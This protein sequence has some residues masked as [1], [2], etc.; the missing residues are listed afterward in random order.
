VALFLTGTD[1]S[2]SAGGGIH[3]HSRDFQFKTDCWWPPTRVSCAN[4]G[5]SA[6]SA[7]RQA[8]ER[9]LRPVLM[10]TWVAMLG[11]L[12]AAVSA[13]HRLGNPETAGHRGHRR[14]TGAGDPAPPACNPRCSCW[15]SGRPAPRRKPGSPKGDRSALTVVIACAI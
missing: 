7:A 5:E 4:G 8:A 10:S 3:F 9:R 6:V 11:L 12:P 14:G 2:T 1:F 15:L 13:Q